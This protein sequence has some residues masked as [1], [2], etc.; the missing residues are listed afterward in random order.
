M[1][2][3][4]KRIVTNGNIYTA[5]NSNIIHKLRFVAKH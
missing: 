1:K 5:P 4:E 2:V 3:I